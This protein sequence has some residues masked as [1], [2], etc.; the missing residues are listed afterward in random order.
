M[1]GGPIIWILLT[2]IFDQTPDAVLYALASAMILS[3]TG[4]AGTLFI[5]RQWKRACSPKS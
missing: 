1:I 2:P 3:L 4:Y 5:F